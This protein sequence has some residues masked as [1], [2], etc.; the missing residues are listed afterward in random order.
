MESSEGP[1][2]QPMLEVYELT[3]AEVDAAIAAF[4]T[5]LEIEMAKF[6]TLSGS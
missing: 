3:A 2:N 4:R 1:P 6:D 5:A